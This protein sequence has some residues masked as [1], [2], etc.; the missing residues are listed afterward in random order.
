MGRKTVFILSG[1]VLT[2]GAIWAVQQG[3]FLQKSAINVIGVKDFSIRGGKINL[4]PQI[5]IQNKSS[6]SA[7]I[8]S[9]EVEALIQEGNSFKKLAATKQPVAGKIP[10]RQS[11]ILSPQIEVPIFSALTTALTIFGVPTTKVNVLIKV[12]AL[13]NGQRITAEDIVTLDV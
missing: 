3:I 10:A 7:T 11:T 12:N 5:E 8:N 4:S 1:L 13:V 9:L 6:I 2:G